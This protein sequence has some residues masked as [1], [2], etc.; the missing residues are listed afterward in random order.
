MPKISNRKA[1]RI[2]K[3]CK[4]AST[5]MYKQGK[6]T[7]KTLDILEK[8]FPEY[9]RRTIKNYIYDNNRVESI[10]KTLKPN[11]TFTTV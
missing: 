2:L 5:L 8:E 11:S 7:K 9:A 6:T 1:K 10:K 4:R 3:M